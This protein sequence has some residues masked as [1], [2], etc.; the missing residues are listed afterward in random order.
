MHAKIAG[1]DYGFDLKKWHDHLKISGDGGYTWR[2]NI[3][4]PK[5]MKEA[6]ASKE[7][8]EA[9]ERIQDENT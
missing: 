7:W 8:N 5:I 6:L 1:T 9:I 3:V 4:L 2:K